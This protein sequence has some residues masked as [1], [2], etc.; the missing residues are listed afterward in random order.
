MEQLALFDTMERKIARRCE[1]VLAD[2]RREADSVV[3]AARRDA[4]VA[5]R[6]ALQ[7]LDTELCEL[8]DQCRMRA[9]GQAALDTLGFQQAAADDVLRRV[10]AELKR[11]ARS[12]SFPGILDALVDEVL[13]VAPQED[14][15]LEVPAEQAARC[16]D[17][18][19]GIGG[20]TVLASSGLTDGVVARDGQGRFRFV[21]TL[22]SRFAR[23]RG[24]ARKLCINRLFEERAAAH[25]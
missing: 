1:H 11:V 7:Q 14:I 17:R 23:L 21:N 13:A 5:R 19:L 16:R 15:I 6:E 10:E 3:E 9:R 2:A 24:D 4:D 18:A 8:A 25:D 12:D 22:S 20:V